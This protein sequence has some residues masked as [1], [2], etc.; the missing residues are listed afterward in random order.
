[1]APETPATEVKK[2]P[3]KPTRMMVLVEGVFIEFAMMWK[4]LLSLV[5]ILLH[6][7]AN[8]TQHDARLRSKNCD[9]EP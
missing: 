6:T 4:F 8:S 5:G 2:H 3:N 9:Q 1:M 7:T